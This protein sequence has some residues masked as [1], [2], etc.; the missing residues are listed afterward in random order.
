MSD[1]ANDLAKPRLETP[2]GACDTHMHF[3]DAAYPSAA[4][5]SFTPPDAG[6]ADY[7]ELQQRLGLQ[8]VVIVQ[9]S[10]YGR[11]N[12]CQLENAWPSATMPA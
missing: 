5:A 8:R 6:V 3:Y 1:G 10:S 2:P 9:P 7:K 12:A 4:T 11:D